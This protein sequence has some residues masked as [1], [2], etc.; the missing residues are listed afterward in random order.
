MFRLDP[1]SKEY[2]R[3]ESMVRQFEKVLLQKSK[4]LNHGI[5][6]NFYIKQSE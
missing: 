5:K 6:G 1:T 4:Q 3:D 2:E